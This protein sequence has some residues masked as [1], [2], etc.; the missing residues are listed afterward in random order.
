MY[1]YIKNGKL[2]CTS[3]QLIE[4]QQEEILG[5][6]RETK[7]VKRWKTDQDGNPVIGEDGNQETETIEEELIKSVVVTPFKEGLVYDEVIEYEQEGRVCYENGKIIPWEES[8]EKEKE[9][10]E[11]EERIRKDQEEW[12]KNRPSQIVELLGKLTTEHS[13]IKALG[14]DTTEIDAQIGALKEEYKKMKS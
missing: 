11:S 14:E 3:N 12:I 5:E 9:D 13:G 6:I 10:T 2:D 4:K 1:A 8:E 7:E